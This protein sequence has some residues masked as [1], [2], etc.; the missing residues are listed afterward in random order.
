MAGSDDPDKL[1][2]DLLALYAELRNGMRARW[3]RDL[4]F[5]ELM[6]D[7]W[8]RARS[9]GFGEGASIYH[10]SLVYGPVQ[11]GEQTWI[12]PMTILDGSGGLRIGRTCSISAGV[13]IYSHDSVKWALSGGTA[14]CE[15]SPVAI[16]NCCYI[17]PN[18]IIARGV[19]I[20][21]HVVVGAGSFVDRDVPPF[22][23]VVGT[24]ARVV[25]R[26]IVD[27]PAVRLE[28]AGAGRA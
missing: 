7:R 2:A 26:V 21:D 20:G 15:R 13:Q 9:L 24:P 11:V 22:S 4:P 1:R 28:F 17:G 18:S 19:T 23:I 6:F 16:G 10:S 5:D 14:A 8:E 3:S 12:G 25:G 27:G